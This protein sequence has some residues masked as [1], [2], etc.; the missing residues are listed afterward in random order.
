MIRH[1]PPAEVLLDYATGTAPMPLAVLVATHL[2][3]CPESRAEVRA[4]E[5]IGGALLDSLA[6]VAPAPD[7]LAAIFKRIDAGE[8]PQQELPRVVPDGVVPPPLADY[9]PGGLDALAWRRL[10]GGLRQAELPFSTATH[11]AS[12]LRIA[13]GRGIPH[14]THRG[15][16]YILVLDGAFSDEFGHYAR[17]DVAIFNETVTHHPVADADNACLCLMVTEGPVRLTS[18]WGRFINPFLR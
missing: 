15:D 10:I 14:H 3:L 18:W 12:L 4:L 6:P 9:L 11:K 1:R 7:A 2:S 13:G 5:A 16:E 17:G 8:V